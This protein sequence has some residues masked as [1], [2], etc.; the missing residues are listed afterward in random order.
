MRKEDVMKK[1][2]HR[3]VNNVNVTFINVPFLETVVFGN[4]LKE[5]TVN[6]LY[7]YERLIKSDLANNRMSITVDFEKSYHATGYDWI[8]PEK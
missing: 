1:E 2:L 8:P 4:M 7:E 3:K 5:E 6:K